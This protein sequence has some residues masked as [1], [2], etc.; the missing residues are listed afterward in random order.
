M[1]IYNHILPEIPSDTSKQSEGLY[2]IDAQSSS[3]SPSIPKEVSVEAASDISPHCHHNVEH[4][5]N[6]DVKLTAWM[7]WTI[8][9]FTIEVLSYELDKMS[10][11]LFS[12]IDRP[13]LKLIFDVEDIVSSLDFQN[14]YLKF[15]SK[16][17][18]ASIYH[19]VL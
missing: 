8:T 3:G 11:K 14:V 4:T 16:I 17:G 1:E 10:S 19:Y 9:K 15:K 12:Y 18:S 5:N 2:V 13:N 6:D 7:Q